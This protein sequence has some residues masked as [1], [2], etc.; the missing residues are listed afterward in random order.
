LARRKHQSENEVASAAALA[1]AQAA[2][3]ALSDSEDEEVRED[4]APTRAVEASPDS[5][6]ALQR[7][8]SNSLTRT[9]GPDPRPGEDDVAAAIRRYAPPRKLPAEVFK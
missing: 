2:W 7:P 5:R 6:R 8:R 3:A 1:A 4:T 9:R